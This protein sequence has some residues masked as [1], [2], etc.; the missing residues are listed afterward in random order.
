MGTDKAM[1]VL[2]G[3]TLVELQRRK[4]SELGISDIIVSGYGEAMQPDD[5]PGQGPLGGLLTCLKLAEND[6]CIVMPVDVPLLTIQTIEELIRCHEL[7]DTPVTIAGHGEREEYLIGIYDKSVVPV[8]EEQLASG[9]RSI[10][11]LLERAGYSI[12]HSGEA[13]DTYINCNTPEAYELLQSR[14]SL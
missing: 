12:A 7:G 14:L 4:L 1:L 2:G 11:A 13:E 9:K 6:A 3:E 8:I 5:M 10:R